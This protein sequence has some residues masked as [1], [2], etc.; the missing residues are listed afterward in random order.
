MVFSKRRYGTMKGNDL[1]DG[2]IFKKD[3]QTGT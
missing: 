2:R 1:G 3:M